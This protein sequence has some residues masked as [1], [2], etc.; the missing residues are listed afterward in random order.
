MIGCN[1][2]S[3]ANMAKEISVIAKHPSMT[4]FNDDYFHNDCIY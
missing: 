1:L 4:H 3:A 2:H